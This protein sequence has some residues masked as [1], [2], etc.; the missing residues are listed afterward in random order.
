MLDLLV[1]APVVANHV[2]DPDGPLAQA[3]R[4][5]LVVPVL[6]TSVDE[7]TLREFGVDGRVSATGLIVENADIAAGL[8]IAGA[9]QQR[10][11]LR[12]VATD[13]PGF[14][15]RRIASTDPTRL[16]FQV[17]LSDAV[18]VPLIEGDAALRCLDEL[19]LLGRLAV[20]AETVGLMQAC[21]DRAV[22]YA[23]ER[24]QFGR[25]I[26]SFQAV[27]HL[28]AGVWRD[29]YSL[30]STCAVAADAIEQGRADAAD[31]A[32]AAKVWAALV[33]RASIEQTLQAQ[34]AIAFTAEHP[35]H[36]FLKRALALEGMFGETPALLRGVGH[37]L[38]TRAEPRAGA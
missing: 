15:A 19:V 22:S 16:A 14:S 18:A 5:G 37:E 4:H 10:P 3:V 1:A 2:G 38:A 24:K 30:D 20:A 28:L 21:L 8:V 23:K 36:L 12:Y 35:Q 25:T 9:A 11:T 26:G 17:D 6:V 34:G 7:W 33:G 32:D 31:L 29:W 13:Q 27:K